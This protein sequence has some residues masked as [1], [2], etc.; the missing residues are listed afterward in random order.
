MRVGTMTSLFRERRESDEY[1]GYPE[2][3]RRCAEAGFEVLDMNLCALPRRR[4]TLHHDDWKQQVDVIRSE[5]E[6]YGLPFVQSHPPYR[7][8]RDGRSFATPED[9]QFFDEM[10][11]RSIEIS[12]MLGCKWAVMH[13][14]TA[15]G[16]EDGDI[17]ASIRYNKELFADAIKLADKLN[18]G[19][20]FENMCDT[21]NRRRF[22]CTAQELAALVDSF[23]SDKVGACWDVG[24]AHRFYDDQVP[25]ILLLGDR[26]KALHIDDNIGD[27]DQHRLPFTGTLPWEKVMHA[28]YEGGCK[29]DM[30][31]EI[32]TTHRMPAA[33]QDVTARYCC[34]VGRYLVSLYK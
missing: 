13:P 22:C 20:A 4:T 8:G 3:V 5:A 1:I 9:E 34:E 28:L 15:V 31:F 2:A 24:H 7:T 26:I 23:H 14:V 11:L 16:A 33:L 21:A 18:V 12:A 17:E 30:I 10:L 6:K 19:L 27:T 25:A 29:A 32:T